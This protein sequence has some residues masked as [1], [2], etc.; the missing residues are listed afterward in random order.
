MKEYEFT[1]IVAGDLTDEAVV[2][3]LYEAGC[4]DATVG[5]ID[6]VGIIS[7]I[8]DASSLTDALT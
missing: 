3:A 6:G 5:V 4:D 7:F 8:R 1:L 2:D